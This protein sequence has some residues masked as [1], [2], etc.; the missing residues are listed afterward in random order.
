M[1]K[2]CLGGDAKT[3]MFCQVAPEG[4]NVSEST[5]SLEFARRTRRVK[6]K[7][8][9]AKV[10]LAAAPVAV[11]PMVPVPKTH[12]GGAGGGRKTRSRSKD[13]EHTRGGGS[14]GI[15]SPS[16]ASASTPAS[17]SSSSSS[18]SATLASRR[19]SIKSMSLSV[20]T[21]GILDT[22]HEAVEG[23]DEEGGDGGDANEDEEGGLLQ[24]LVSMGQNG[25]ATR[26]TTGTPRAAGSL[27]H[28]S[29]ATGGG[30][31]NENGHDN[32]HGAENTNTNTNT[33]MNTTQSAEEIRALKRQVAHWRAQYEEERRRH[34]H[35]GSQ[36]THGGTHGGG[37]AAA[38][39]VRAASDSSA[40]RARVTS[41]E[42]LDGGRATGHNPGRAS[43]IHT[44]KKSTATIPA[45]AGTG[46]G[47]LAAEEERRDR[48]TSSGSSTG[49]ASTGESPQQKDSAVSGWGRFFGRGKRGN[50][51]GAR[52]TTPK[53]PAAGKGVSGWR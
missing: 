52:P 45:A 3:L 39:R 24:E 8:G 35:A 28:R 6:N 47:G 11:V 19:M 7:A 16:S 51:G 1:L 27:K 10:S 29:K 48:A 44:P 20:D 41:R 23:G 42:G 49:S 43:Y 34:G 4:T 50:R 18:L 2:D 21:E 30:V 36:G 37:G 33:S 22:L 40:G 5:S 26:A 17:S 14:T 12:R 46:T 32:G 13:G 38:R 31:E 53:A 15:L 25:S 9:G